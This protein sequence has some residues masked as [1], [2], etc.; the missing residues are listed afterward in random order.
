MTS[1]HTHLQTVTGFYWLRALLSISIVYWHMPSTGKTLVFDY[2]NLSNHIFTLYDFFNFYVLLLGVPTFFLMSLYL[3]ARI[4]TMHYLRKRIFRFLMF[5][6]FWTVA[7][8]IWLFG[9]KGL[10]SLCPHSL[11]SFTL[12][13][14]TSGDTIGYF[15]VSLIIL[16]IMTYIFSNF[17][18]IINSIFLFLAC[19]IIFVLPAITINYSFFFLSAFYNPLN[20]IPYPFAAILIVRSER[21]F[22]VPSPNNHHDAA[23]DYGNFT[24]LL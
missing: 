2:S 23:S 14:L 13:V 16:T 6:V 9:Y 12:L 21:F 3:F 1:S 19:I 10:L 8:K 18:A 5:A 7:M 22:K 11:T 20:F 4:P 15:F 24:W 17:S